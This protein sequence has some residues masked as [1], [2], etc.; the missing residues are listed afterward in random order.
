VGTG[1]SVILISGLLD[2]F[3]L[4]IK[5]FFFDYWLWNDSLS[6]SEEEEKNI[7]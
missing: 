6:L 7:K 5:Y 1:S 3:F 2:M 4:K